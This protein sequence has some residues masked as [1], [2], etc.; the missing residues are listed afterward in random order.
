MKQAWVLYLHH[1]NNAK[2]RGIEF[3]FTF[4]EWV[5]WWVANLGPDWMIKRGRRKHEYC[6]ARKGDVGPYAPWNVDCITNQQ[7]GLLQ[8]ANGKATGRG[9]QKLTAELARAIF[10]SRQAV[11]ALAAQ[12]GLTTGVVRDIKYRRIWKAATA[13]LHSAPILNVRSK[14]TKAETIEVFYAEGR[15]IDIA[16][17]FGISRQ[18]VGQIKRGGRR[19]DYLPPSLLINAIS[20]L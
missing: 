19:N 6:M 3:L 17:R 5:A 7:N 4:E 20:Q 15:H 16:A 1:K 18:N 9:P 8:K 11:P 2:R 14:L 12:Y 10:R 13:H